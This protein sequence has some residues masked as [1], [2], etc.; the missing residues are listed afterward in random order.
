MVAGY[1]GRWNIDSNFLK[2]PIH[3]RLKDD[4][5][6]GDN[7][8]SRS[9]TK[10]LFKPIK[11]IMYCSLILSIFDLLNIMQNLL[12]AE[13]YC[14]AKFKNIYIIKESGIILLYS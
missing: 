10:Y 13:N 4:N 14:E 6:E 3:W 2:H 9:G 5:K 12:T 7:Y 1:K 11:N 8:L